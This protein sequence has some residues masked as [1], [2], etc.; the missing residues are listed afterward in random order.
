[1]LSGDAARVTNRGGEL[2]NP[3][4]VDRVYGTDRVTWDSRGNRDGGSGQQADRV[5][6][7]SRGNRESNPNLGNSNRVGNMEQK[8]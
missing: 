4:R 5:T 8:T 1:M 2:G 6:R 7:V 3:N